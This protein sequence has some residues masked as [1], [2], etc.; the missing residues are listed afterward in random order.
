[1]ERPRAT[2]LGRAGLLLPL[3]LASACAAVPDL[4]PKPVPAAASNYASAQSLAG[5]EAAW[6]AD[7]WW[8]LYRD[9]QLDR[10]IGEDCRIDS[11]YLSGR[12]YS[13]PSLPRAALLS[14]LCFFIC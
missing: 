6:P 3:L 10:L 5:S 13:R 8:T 4:G 9:P 12:L 7:G 14:L 2:R 1:M 11:N